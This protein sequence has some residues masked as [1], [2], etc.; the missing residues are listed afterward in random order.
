[1]WLR[2]FH[3]IYSPALAP[4]VVALLIRDIPGIHL[5]MLGTDKGDGSFQRTQRVAVDFGVRHVL[6][7]PGAIAKHDIP[8]R[9][10]QA[11]VFLNTARIDNTPVSVLE[12]M[13]CGLC[14]VS[15][16]VGGISA[17][18]EDG[19]DALLVP[20]NDPRAMADAIRRIVTEPDLAARLSRNARRKAEKFDWSRILPR[21]KA[22]LASAARRQ[23]Q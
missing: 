2:A 5:T 14:I 10:Y 15:T 9:L 3:E 16:K 4:Q 11:D 19:R 23:T 20:P 1:V 7:M 6:D 21:W 8:G 13:L 12:A 17:L 18:L 22:L